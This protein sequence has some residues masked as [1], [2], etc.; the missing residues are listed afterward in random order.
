MEEKL[1]SLLRIALGWVFIIL[2]VAGLFLPFLQGVLFLLIG[3]YLLSHESP[4]AKDL[5]K[6]IRQRFPA[7]A[8]KLDQVKAKNKHLLKRIRKRGRSL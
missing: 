3:L 4:R 5:L 8:K 2:G 1:K 6:K 7:L